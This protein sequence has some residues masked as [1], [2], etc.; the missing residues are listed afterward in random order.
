[1]QLLT[2]PL[3]TSFGLC[4]SGW[5][6]PHGRCSVRP[7]LERDLELRRGVLWPADLGPREGQA[8]AGLPGG[9]AADLHPASGVQVVDL[10]EPSPNPGLDPNRQAALAVVP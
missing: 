2:L 10:D 7:G 3:K 4:C 9:H 5:C 8:A 1:M 6:E